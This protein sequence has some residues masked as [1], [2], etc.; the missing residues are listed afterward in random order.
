M[1][2]LALSALVLTA[3]L[4]LGVE[5]VS[6]QE[7]AGDPEPVEWWHRAKLDPWTADSVEVTSFRVVVRDGWYN[8]FTDLPYWK[9]YY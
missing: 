9:D 4:C 2:T 6:A 7:V 5:S 8:A 3:M 1:E